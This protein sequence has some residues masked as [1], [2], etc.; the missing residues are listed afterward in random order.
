[1]NDMAKR[2]EHMMAT[3]ALL[4]SNKSW[5]GINLRKRRALSHH[6]T[7]IDDLLVFG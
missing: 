1:M 3:R 6:Y 4:Q 5:I 2:S 7:H